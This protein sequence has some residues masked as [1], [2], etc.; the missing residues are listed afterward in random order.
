[1]INIE[2]QLLEAYPQFRRIW[3]QY[4]NHRGYRV[5]IT[6]FPQGHE[7]Y[8]MLFGEPKDLSFDSIN[9]ILQNYLRNKVEIAQ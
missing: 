5:C 1:M 7:R 9:A 8:K 2:S 3:V 4:S 6:L